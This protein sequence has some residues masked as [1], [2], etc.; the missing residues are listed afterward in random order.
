MSFARRAAAP[1]LGIVLSLVLLVES[2]GLDEVARGDQ[3]GPGFWPRLALAGLG[4]ACAAK[5]VDAWR[6]RHAR[7][8]RESSLGAVGDLEPEAVS[9]ISRPRLATGIILI[10]LYVAATPRIGFPVATAAFIVTFMGLC[11][12]R[13]ILALAANASIGTTGL[14]YLFVKLVYLPLPKGTGPF[15]TLTLALYRA[16]R[17]F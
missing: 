16:L 13:S 3:L 2:R 6:R 8:G 9:E 7:P 4:L 5:I 11:G 17:I 14:L 10:V 12:T 15:E 1:L